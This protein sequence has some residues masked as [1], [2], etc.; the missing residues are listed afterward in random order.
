MPE[1]IG[2][3][4]IGDVFFGLEDHG[5]LTCVI[6]VDYGGSGQG[7][8]NY[9]LGNKDLKTTLKQPNYAGAFVVGVLRTLEKE[10]LGKLSGTPVRVKRE[11]GLILGLGHF[12]KDKWFFPREML[13]EMETEH[14]RR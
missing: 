14:G 3:A 6:S 11:N 12:I 1:D 5:L 9:M 10:D 8:G 7:F 13:A 2:N 4:V